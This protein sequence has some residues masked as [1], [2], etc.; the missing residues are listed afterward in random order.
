[1]HLSGSCIASAMVVREDNR[2]VELHD[3][4]IALA[5]LLQEEP[6]QRISLH[7]SQSLNITISAN[8]KL[9]LPRD[10]WIADAYADFRA[11]VPT[12]EVPLRLSTGSQSSADAAQYTAEV[13]FMRVCCPFT[14]PIL[15][16]GIPAPPDILLKW[17]A[18]WFPPN[19]RRTFRDETSSSKLITHQHNAETTSY[20]AGVCHI[21]PIPILGKVERTLC[22]NSQ[23][24]PP[25][26]RELDVSAK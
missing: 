19:L 10:F 1:M 26:F 8:G 7:A 5:Y 6:E 15:C 21:G 17:T 4:C 16:L 12:G 14:N 9:N 13:P 23:T 3:V 20:L 24:A 18:I 25:T 22:V 2:E 11:E